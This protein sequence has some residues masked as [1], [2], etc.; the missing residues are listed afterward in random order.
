MQIRFVGQ[1]DLSDYVQTLDEQDTKEKK[2][3]DLTI[4]A[5]ND[6]EVCYE[7]ELKGETQ[8]FENVAKLSKR[9]KNLVI[10]GVVTNAHGHRRKSAIVTENGRILGVSD[11]IYAID[12]EVHSGAFLRVYDTKI[13]RVG[14]VV[15][16]DLYDV[17]TVKTLSLCGCDFIVCPFEKVQDSVCSVLIRAYAFICGVPILFCGRGNAMIADVDATLAFASPLSPVRAE[18]T[19][20]KEFHLLER[21]RKIYLKQK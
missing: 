15:A 9:D 11:M 19:V 13:G 4:F 10:C 14:I 20:K 3:D 2:K 21:R 6:N 8:F 18:F 7:R 5:F 12:G 17:E 1:G 16:E